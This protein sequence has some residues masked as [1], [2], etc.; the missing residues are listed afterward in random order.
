MPTVPPVTPTR[1]ARAVAA[2]ILLLRMKPPRVLLCEWA[3]GLAL[4]LRFRRERSR[5]PP[6]R[7]PLLARLRLPGY[8]LKA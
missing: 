8:F 5:Y 1:T 4:P 6:G 7:T 2:E 3:K